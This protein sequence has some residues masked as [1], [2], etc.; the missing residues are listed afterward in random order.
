[1]GQRGSVGTVSSCNVTGDE[2]E[3]LVLGGW[4]VVLQD[5][6]AKG[7]QDKGGRP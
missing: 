6:G 2:D 7:S 5:S 1:M 4:D 3:E